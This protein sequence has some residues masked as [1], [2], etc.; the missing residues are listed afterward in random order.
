MEP[1]AR[2]FFVPWWK[3]VIEV[4]L[5]PLAYLCQK[6]QKSAIFKYQTVG[7]SQ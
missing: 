3:L 2:A 6:T 1:N 7:V 4:K 5:L